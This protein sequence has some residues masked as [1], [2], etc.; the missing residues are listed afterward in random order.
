MAFVPGHDDVHGQR[1]RL[2]PV[3]ELLRDHFAQCVLKHVR[4]AGVQPNDEL[5]A[6]DLAELAVD[7]EDTAKW[8]RGAGKE[9]L[10]VFLRERLYGCEEAR[11]WSGG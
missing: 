8:A 3:D 5:D 4:G 6:V 7:L 2:E 10:E 11:A 1:L 9:L